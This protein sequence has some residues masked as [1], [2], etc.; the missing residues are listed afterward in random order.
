[1]AAWELSAD[2]I[3]RVISQYKESFAA[4][5]PEEAY[6]WRGSPM[7]PGALESRELGFCR[8]AEGI[9][10]PGGKSAGHQLLVSL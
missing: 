7:L 4:W 6:K 1:M 3:R 2:P 8:N 9:L 5:F 10:G